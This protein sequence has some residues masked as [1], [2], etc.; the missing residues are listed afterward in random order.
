MIAVFQSTNISEAIS[1]AHGKPRGIRLFLTPSS[2]FNCLFWTA[3]FIPWHPIFFYIYAVNHSDVLCS[4]SSL[5]DPMASGH[6]MAIVCTDSGQEFL[7]KLQ[8]ALQ[9][10]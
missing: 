7:V 6:E 2:W 4:F 5:A 10:E 3:H 1:L 9:R 8:L